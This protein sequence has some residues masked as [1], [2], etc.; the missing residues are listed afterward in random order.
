LRVALDYTPA[1]NQAAG[2][3][4]YT[5]SLFNALASV[6]GEDVDW[7]LWYPQDVDGEPFLPRSERVT[8]VQLPLSAR[9]LNLLWHRLGIP[10]RLDRYTGQVSVVHGTDFVVPPSRAPSVVTVHDLSYAIHPEFA[11]PRLQRYLARA[12]PRSIDRA[13]RVIAVSESTKRDICEYYEIAPHR[14]EVIHHGADP[15]FHQPTDTEIFSSLAQ[16]G[17]RRP[18]F[19]TVGTVEPRKDHRTLLRAF[20]RVR[21]ER[22]DVSL[23][24]VGRKGWL[25]DDIMNEISNAAKRSP[26]FHLQ[27]IRDDMLPALYGGSTAMVYPARYEGFGLPVLEAMATGTPVIAS[28][29]PALRETASENALYAE[30]G[31]VE[32]F[33]EHMVGLLTDEGRRARLATLGLQR[34]SQFSW[35]RAAREHLRVYR[36]V[37]GE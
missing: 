10:L 30:P 7:T 6:A 9:W 21:Q 37:A 11:F 15:L 8:G 14:V 32:G 24:I 34:A 12:V 28:T 35:E 3:G 29:T 20:E 31:D 36:E 1:I 2:V 27:D 18:Y 16:F 17:L 4:R 5:R 33:A 25:S 26:V 19:V 22:D 13:R 23:V